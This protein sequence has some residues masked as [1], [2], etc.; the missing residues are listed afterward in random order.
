M[1]PSTGSHRA[2]GTVLVSDT[3]MMTSSSMVSRRKSQL[4]LAWCRAFSTQMVAWLTSYDARVSRLSNQL[5]DDRPG[6][7]SPKPGRQ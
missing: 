4:P 7:D 1:A 6:A 3:A 2:A 5:I